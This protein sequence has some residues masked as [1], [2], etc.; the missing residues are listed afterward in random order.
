MG[1]YYFN[2]KDDLLG[3]GELGTVV[4][5]YPRGNMCGQLVALKIIRKV[6]VSSIKYATAMKQEIYVHK[7]LSEQIPRVKGQPNVVQLYQVLENDK[8]IVLVMEYCEKGVLSDQ[9]K[10]ISRSKLPE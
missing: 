6:S 10:R 4:R 3:K 2:S 7:K 1:K 9:V 8:Y 5:A